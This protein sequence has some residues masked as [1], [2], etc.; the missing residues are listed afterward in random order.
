MVGH[1]EAS[2]QCWFAFCCEKYHQKR[3]CQVILAHNTQIK[4]SGLL[5]KDKG[6]I[7]KTMLSNS[8]QESL[9]RGA[10]RRVGIDID[11]GSDRN[12]AVPKRP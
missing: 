6:A 11:R 12:F 1:D 10:H 2:P 5:A 8:L 9:V 3:E 4:F 7:L